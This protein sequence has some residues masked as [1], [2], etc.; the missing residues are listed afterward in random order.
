MGTLRVS[1]GIDEL[2]WNMPATRPSDTR[3][4]SLPNGASAAASSAAFA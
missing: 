3:A 4:S 2:D 1:A